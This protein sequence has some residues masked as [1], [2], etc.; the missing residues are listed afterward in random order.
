MSG[1]YRIAVRLASLHRL[2]EKHRCGKT[3]SAISVDWKVYWLCGDGV[4]VLLCTRLRT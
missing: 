1:T 3:L 4:R 2:R